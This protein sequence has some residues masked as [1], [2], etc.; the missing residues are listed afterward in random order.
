MRIFM[1]FLAVLA[2]CSCMP[3]CG[4]QEGNAVYPVV[5][6]AEPEE[7]R[8]SCRILEG[9]VELFCLFAETEAR[10]WQADAAAQAVEQ[11]QAAADLLEQ[12]AAAC[13]QK[14]QIG[15]PQ[16]LGK[17]QYGGFISPEGEE[18]MLLNATV[19]A[20]LDA[21]PLENAVGQA[22]YVV[23]VCGSGQ[24]YA[25]PQLLA[26][27]E[28]LHREKVVVYT[29]NMEAPQLAALLAMLFGRQE[30]PFTG[31]VW[32]EECFSREFREYLGCAGDEWLAE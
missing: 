15:Q 13:G 14:L 30:V 8:G 2:A 16:L 4:K 19:E 10:P 25:L 28:E 18:A 9:E 1:V 5:Q 31:Q 29:E 7:R 24:S 12:Q 26:G 32:Q 17:L 23:L 6:K 22:A 27:E 20:W 11:L 21:Q 3:A